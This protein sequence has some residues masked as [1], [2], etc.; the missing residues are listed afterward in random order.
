[1]SRLADGFLKNRYW[2]LC[3]VVFILMVFRTDNS[4]WVGD[5]W[6]HSS[7]IRELAT[8]PWQPQHPQ[9]LIDAPHAF[10]TPY[11]L[12]LAWFSRLSGKSAVET[13]AIA[14]LVN[15]LLYFSG[16]YLFI[17]TLDR[18]KRRGLAFYGLLLTL[19]VWGMYAWNFSGF[20][21]LYN[22][23]FVIPFPSTFA[24]AISLWALWLNARRI[25]TGR[26]LLLLPIWLVAAFVLL[27]HSITFFFLAAGLAA[28]TWQSGQRFW[29]EILKIVALLLLAFGLAALWPYYPFLKLML[30][31]SAVY[32]LSNRDLYQ[33][34]AVRTWP[35]WFGLPLL[36]LEFRRDWRRP[37]PWMFAA[38]LA[39]YLLGWVTGAYS[40]GRVMSYLGILLQISMAG[41]LLKLEN[42]LIE[43]RP[44][45]P[46]RPALFS[47]GVTAALLL[48]TLPTQ[49]IPVIKTVAPEDG[50]HLE[51]YLFLAEY[52]GQYEVILTDLPT[53]MIV[54]TFGGKVVAYDRPLAFVTDSAQRKA[55]VLGFYDPQTSA[56]ARWE[57]LDKYQVKYILLEKKPEANWEA[58]RPLVAAYGDLIYR[59]KRF[60]LYQVTGR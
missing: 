19:L 35:L 6:E 11:H 57:I 14:G 43:Q 21:Q 59:G 41:F 56:A 13:L 51:K 28:F 26:E 24:M 58:V 48:V 55:D 10:N 36:Y 45:A 20:Y 17:S 47:L 1:M 49:L 9:L 32:H 29:G 50:N 15:L 53:S 8:H 5:F 44:A 30:G 16:F 52:T 18:E 25:E 38:L 42:R 4:F 2:L 39:V 33:H 34:L 12:L 37:L 23:G 46:G 22:L 60:L 7:V 27:T 54:P 3:G 40:Y 31:E